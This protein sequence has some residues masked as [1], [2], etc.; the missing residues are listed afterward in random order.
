MVSSI[1]KF[2]FNFTY[3]KVII[4]TSS[5]SDEDREKALSY[6]F[7]HGYINKPLNWIKNSAFKYLKTKLILV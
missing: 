7:V 5:I 3:F 4:V 6:S 1:R 2:N